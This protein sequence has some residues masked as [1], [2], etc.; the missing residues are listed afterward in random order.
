MH[1]QPHV[2]GISTEQCSLMPIFV[3]TKIIALQVVAGG[4]SSPGPTINFLL[5]PR[6]QT[7][8]SSPVN[9]GNGNGLRGIHTFFKKK[10][11]HFEL[12]KWAPYF[13]RNLTVCEDSEDQFCW[14]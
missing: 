3:A 10:M 11:P 9:D 12:M 5:P 14:V 1:G 8:I 6:K 2:M 7:E 13:S 4:Y